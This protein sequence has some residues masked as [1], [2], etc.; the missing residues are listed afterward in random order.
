MA[1]CSFHRG[2]LFRLGPLPLEP[3]C[4]VLVSHVFMLLRASIGV[5]VFQGI[6]HERDILFGQVDFHALILSTRRR[7]CPRQQVPLASDFFRAS[8]GAEPVLNLRDVNRVDS[9]G[10]DLHLRLAN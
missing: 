8:A 6:D 4:S 7:L 9:A 3:I 5:V 10:D 2:W 1:A